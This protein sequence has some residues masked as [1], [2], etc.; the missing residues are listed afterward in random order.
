MA[1]Q[2]NLWSPILLI[3][4]VLIIIIIIVAT[5]KS[6]SKNKDE[7]FVHSRN[8]GVMRDMW[9][10]PWACENEFQCCMK[11][12]TSH[13]DPVERS[14]HSLGRTLSGNYA[15]QP[16][17][18]WDFPVTPDERLRYQ[19]CDLRR[20]LCRMGRLNNYSDYLGGK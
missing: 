18:T 16:Y 11:E 4:L 9:F 6:S 3:L 12:K 20:R 2:C 13:Y 8:M 15:I 7:N 5:R 10:T 14:A 19:K 1:S 17:N